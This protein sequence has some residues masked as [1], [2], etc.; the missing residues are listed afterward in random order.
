[1]LARQVLIGY[2]ILLNQMTYV[3]LINIRFFVIC[4]RQDGRSEM[5]NYISFYGKMRLQ[6]LAITS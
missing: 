1:M 2:Q 4:T 3:L 5:P 6:R